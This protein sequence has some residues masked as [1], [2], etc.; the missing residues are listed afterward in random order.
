MKKILLVGAGQLG[1]RHLQSLA[2]CDFPV[3]IFVVDPSKEALQISNERLNQ[4]GT[5]RLVQP[6]SFHTSINE[7]DEE[8]F[9]IGVI[10]TSSNIRLHVINSIIERFKI[11]YM[12]LEKVLFQSEK[13]LSEGLNILAEAKV[14]AWVNCPK[15]TYPLYTS[16]KQRLNGREKI[17]I[18]V[19]G[20][21]WGL[22]CNAIHFID[23]VSYLTGSMNYEVDTSLLEREVVS[24]KRSGFVEFFGMLKFYFDNGSELELSC[25]RGDSVSYDLSIDAEGFTALIN[26]REGNIKI[27]NEN[28]EVLETF[29]WGP[30]FQSNLTHLMVSDILSEGNCALAPVNESIKL[31]Q[32]FISSLL[33]FYNSVMDSHATKLPIT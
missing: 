11:N 9:D 13:E 4:I 23:L 7:I 29:D 24:S 16:I 30:V 26:E 33:S 21:N 6:I 18:K 27:I 19:W 28:R 31:H 5:G 14:N 8:H 20:D 2:K 3:S 10:A 25:G 15:R 22:G 32:G 17:K 12:I 1:S